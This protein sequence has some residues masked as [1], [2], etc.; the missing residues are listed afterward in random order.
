M[1]LKRIGAI[2]AAAAALLIP[3]AAA[4]VS[5]QTANAAPRVSLKQDWTKSE[6]VYPNPVELSWQDRYTKVYPGDMPPNWD[7]HNIY[8]PMRDGG[9]KDSIPWGAPCTTPWQ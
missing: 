1:S 4:T 2:F 7:D 5:A 3:V 8:S 9:F 6:C